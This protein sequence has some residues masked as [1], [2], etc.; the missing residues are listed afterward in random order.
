MAACAQISFL[1]PWSNDVPV[2]GQT[3][4]VLFTAVLL[5]NSPT[6]KSRR[7]LPENVNKYSTTGKTIGVLATTLYLIEG[8]VIGLPFFSSAGH[9]WAA[10]LGP[11]GG[12][13]EGFILASWVVVF[14]SVNL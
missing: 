14:A 8:V 1:P 9:G 13:L 4:G 6:P 3:F 10:L 2:T 5:G 11:T 12:Y 7:G